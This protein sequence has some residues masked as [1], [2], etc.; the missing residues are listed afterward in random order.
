MT[1]TIMFDVNGGREMTELQRPRVVEIGASLVAVVGVFSVGRVAYGV[2]VNLEHDWSSGARAVFLFL[3]SIVLLFG[4][5][6]L[7]LAYHLRRGRMWAWITSLVMLPFTMLFGGLLL[8]ITAVGGGI[9]LAGSAIVAFSLAALLTLSIP[10]TARAYFTRRLTPPPLP[11][12]PMPGQF[13]PMPGQPGP[14]PGQFG[15][16]PVQPGLTSG[17]FGPMPGQPGPMP[18]QPGPMPGQPGPVQSQPWGPGH[19]PA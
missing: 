12:P 18:G 11:Y 15:S 9:P 10:R 16:M 4:L 8:L 7:V 2:V 6:I 3:N 19:P 13:A 17:Q 14:T 1:G 5:F